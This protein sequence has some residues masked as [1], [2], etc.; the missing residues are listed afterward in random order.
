MSFILSALSAAWVFVM[1][2]YWLINNSAGIEFWAGM[3][4]CASSLVLLD[5]AYEY[6]KK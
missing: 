4:M 6:F 3:S 1:A 2:A 5:I